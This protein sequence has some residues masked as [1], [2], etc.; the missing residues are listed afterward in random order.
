MGRRI[1]VQGQ[2]QAKGERPYLKNKVK[3]KNGV[4]A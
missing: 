4:E 2:L 3:E 1:T